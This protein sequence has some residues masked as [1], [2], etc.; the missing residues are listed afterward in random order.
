M[1]I[2][3]TPSARQ[4]ES[5]DSVVVIP[6][7]R[8]PVEDVLKTLRALDVQR[9]T[10]SLRYAVFV[11]INN[12]SSAPAATVQQ[13]QTLHDALCQ[14]LEDRGSWEKLYG[15]LFVG[16]AFSAKYAHPQN[17][18]GHAR[19]IGTAEMLPL[20]KYESTIHA[21]D[22]DTQ[23]GDEYIV[24]GREVFN[25]NI[26]GAA[27][28]PLEFVSNSPLE[29]THYRIY[30]LQMGLRNRNLHALH[31]AGV[32]TALMSGSNMTMRRLAYEQAGGFPAVEGAEDVLL[33]MGIIRAGW[34]ITSDKRLRVHTSMRT[35]DRT[36]PDCGFGQRML[37]A[38]EYANQP[39]LAPSWSPAQG[40]WFR[41]ILESL[42]YTKRTRSREEWISF[43][44]QL[45]P[46]HGPILTLNEAAVL[47]ERIALLPPS[48]AIV[49]NYLLVNDLRRM[50]HARHQSLPLI[51]S[52]DALEQQIIDA[53]SS[54]GTEA[55]FENFA[56]DLRL[57]RSAHELPEEGRL[58]GIEMLDVQWKNM[59]A[60]ERM[61]EL[62]HKLQLGLSA[63]QKSQ[64]PVFE[65]H[66]E[67]LQQTIGTVQGALPALVA[68]HAFVDSL[69]STC[70]T[71]AFAGVRARLDW[72]TEHFAPVEQAAPVLLDQLQRHQR[73]ADAASPILLAIHVAY[74]TAR[75]MLALC[76]QLR[77]Y[78]ALGLPPDSSAATTNTFTQYTV[79]A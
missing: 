23:V 63:L 1:R 70:P 73:A 61:Q 2:Y 19:Q 15:H 42:V 37:S 18:V 35:S 4:V 40:R 9:G 28:G 10:A 34:K 67:A 30:K 57:I 25:D 71:P 46:Q 13:N 51:M 20:L 53:D 75:R 39:S 22:A 69:P 17:N 27:T 58:E 50:A 44:I 52:L 5:Y 72:Y 78:G 3:P 62:R 29:E 6:A 66:K 43:L 32:N 60:A 55:T 74:S 16:D 65:P 54:G 59:H 48:H 33:S 47:A 56:T 64:D 45:T 41:E 8:E 12:H 14:Q 31:D 26:V 24:G 7:Y 79:S 36:H 21:T 38:A 76:Q 68:A 49:C 77:M 11:V